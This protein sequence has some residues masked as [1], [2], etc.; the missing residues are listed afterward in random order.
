MMTRTRSLKI[1]ALADLTSTSVSTIRYYE[2]I[3]LLPKAHRQ[4]GGQ[5]EFTR[6]D[7]RRLTF[8]R[9][10]REFGFSIEQVKALAAVLDDPTSSCSAVRELAAA[11]V[12]A[13]RQKMREMKKLELSLSALVRSCD[14]RCAGGAGP[15][16]VVL[17]DLARVDDDANCGCCAR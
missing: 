8:I 3:G 12:R 10:G 2:Q 15:D 7:V 11:Q 4:E 16:C 5:R 6:G 9:R 17:G 14:E 13:V 1:G